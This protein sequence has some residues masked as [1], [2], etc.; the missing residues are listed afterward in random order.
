MYLKPIENQWFCM[1]SVYDFCVLVFDPSG[2]GL[3]LSLR[4]VEFSSGSRCPEVPLNCFA[5]KF[6]VSRGRFRSFASVRFVSSFLLLNADRALGLRVFVWIVLLRRLR[7]PDVGVGIPNLT[8]G[9]RDAY[10]YACI[11]P[12][13]PIICIGFLR[14]LLLAISFSDA[15]STPK[16][17]ETSRAVRAFKAS[18]TRSTLETLDAFKTPEAPIAF[19]TRF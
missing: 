9:H 7:C 8:S 2:P 5:L 1:T 18:M 6:S 16:T 17:L 13:E 12:G 10:L 15:L 3:V 4:D 19:E 14:T 11:S